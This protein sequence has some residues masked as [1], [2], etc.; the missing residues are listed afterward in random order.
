MGT[1][2]HKAPL[3]YDLPDLQ[4][5]IR[6]SC[7]SIDTEEQYS[8]CTLEAHLAVT[9]APTCLDALKSD[10]VVGLSNDPTIERK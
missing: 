5:E 8:E 7:G 1:G 10:R 3:C 9:A 2:Q 4:S 6:S